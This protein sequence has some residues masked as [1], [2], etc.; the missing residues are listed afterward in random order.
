MFIKQFRYST[1]NLGYLVY[2]TSEGIAIDA[3]GVD[4]ILAF[5]KK[6]HIHIKYISNT[7]SH[8]DHTCGNE[9]LLKKTSAQFIDC[10]QIKSDQTLYLDK[11][12]LEVFHTPGHTEDSITFM[13]DDFAVTGD[14][15][16]NGTIGNCFT[17][18]L[19]VFFLSLKRLMSFPKDTKIYG[20][21]DYVMES[22]EIAKT[23]EKNNPYIEDYIK[24]YNP[25][26]IVSTLDDELRA[27]S[28]IRFNAQSMITLLQKRNL[29]TDTEFARFKSIMETY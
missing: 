17:G 3:G 7:H 26:L 22:M 23:I 13:A 16:F 21:H 11:E 28:Y 4:D 15:L 10:R 5:A 9:T 27:N 24:K 19:S 20:G 18:N 6:N 8:H 12:N 1:D 29:P 14:T 25:G 2:S